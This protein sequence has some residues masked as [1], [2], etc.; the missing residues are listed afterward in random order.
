M[1]SK[2]LI[3]AHFVKCL[4]PTHTFT[5]HQEEE[6]APHQTQLGSAVKALPE[7]HNIK[8]LRMVLAELSQDRALIRSK[9]HKIR[10]LKLK[11]SEVHQLEDNASKG[12]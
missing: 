4:Q 1:N 8:V 12:H 2:S 10:E 6:V 3:L 7:A 11:T 5:S 9:E